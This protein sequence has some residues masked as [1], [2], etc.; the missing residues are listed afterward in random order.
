MARNNSAVGR[1]AAILTTGEVAGAS[2]DLDKAGGAQVVVDLSFTKGSLTN[3]IV[4]FYGSRD[5][6]TFDPI[7]VMSAA[8]TVAT[9]DGT[10]AGAMQPMIDTL[11]A[12]AERMY[13]VPKLPGVKWFRVSIQGTGTVTSS[14]AA[15]NYLYDRL[16]SL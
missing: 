1:A 11:T 7:A 15:F 12:N 9:G 5:G 8:G 4:R 13:V 2:F 10:I 6:T 3:A 16:G 14:S